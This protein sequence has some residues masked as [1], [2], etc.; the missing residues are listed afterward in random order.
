MKKIIPFL[1]TKGLGA[2][3]CGCQ[4]II[5][6]YVRKKTGDTKHTLLVHLHLPSQIGCI[7]SDHVSCMNNFKHNGKFVVHII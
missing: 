4:Y 2:K 3:T 1:R 7:I 6:Q 5:L